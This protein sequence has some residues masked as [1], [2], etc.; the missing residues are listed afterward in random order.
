[1]GSTK[2]PTENVD[3]IMV[4]EPE[5]DMKTLTEDEHQRMDAYQGEVEAVPGG[6][7][8]QRRE[9]PNAGGSNQ[10]APCRRGCEW[11]GEVVL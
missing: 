5:E 7:A 8:V 2:A 6:D 3:G 4:E 1:M 10:V 9:N 11:S